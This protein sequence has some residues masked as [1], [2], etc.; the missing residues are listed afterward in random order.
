MPFL[1]HTFNETQENADAQIKLEKAYTQIEAL[2][3]AKQELEEVMGMFAHK[4]RGPLRSIRNNLDYDSPKQATLESVQTMG[5]LLDIFSIISSNAQ[6]LREQLQQDRQ[7]NGTLLTVL[8]K[9]LSLAIEQLLSIDNIDIIR[10]HY[11]NY[12]KELNK[13]Q[14]QP[15]VNNGSK[16]IMP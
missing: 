9:S 4:F 14:P 11:L 13:C 1:S 16:M 8:K 2:E 10:Q 12:A 5:G 3:K 15:H 6:K 7:G